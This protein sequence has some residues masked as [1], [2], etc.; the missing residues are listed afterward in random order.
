MS[1]LH[2]LEKGDSFALPQ[3]VKLFSGSKVIDGKV[4]FEIVKEIGSGGFGTVYLVKDEQGKQLALKLL[5]LWE[6]HPLDQKEVTYRF[7]REYEA[8]RVASPYIVHSYSHGEVGGNPFILMDYCS[9]GDLR[10]KMNRRWEEVVVCQIA[11]QILK[12]LSHLHQSGIIHRDLKPENVLFNTSNQAMLCDFGISGFL[13]NRSTKADWRGHVKSVF[14][15]IVY[16]P[17]EQLDPRV[18]FKSVG[19]STDIFGFGVLMYELLTQGKLP[20]GN[21]EDFTKDREFF[22]NRVR[23]GEFTDI[24]IYRPDLSA[25]WLEILQYCLQ[26]DPLKRFKSTDDI[27]LRLPSNDSLPKSPLSPQLKIP[28][29][30]EKGAIALLIM[31]GDEYGRFFNLSGLMRRKE[32]PLLTLGWFSKKRPHENDIPIVENF[33]RYVSKYHA[34]IEY[35][36]KKWFIRDGQWREINGVSKWRNS[37]NGTWVNAKQATEDGLSFEPGDILTV[38][39]TT[40]RVVVG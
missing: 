27:L 39:D 32:K 21:I 22:Y 25:L 33:T 26:P 35:S 40:L 8:G 29:S 5:H 34:T 4:I 16:M 36:Q 38:G 12:G 10:R 28:N 15:T 11:R 30:L 14:G 23:K 6:I 9:N 37:K 3:K 24:R 1:N 2:G 7:K 19:P 17:P 20:F 18:A 13:Q 31:N